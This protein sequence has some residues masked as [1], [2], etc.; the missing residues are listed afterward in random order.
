[1]CG[2]FPTKILPEAEEKLLTNPSLMELLPH[3]C[4]Y[5]I[6]YLYIAGRGQLKFYN[7]QKT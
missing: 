5:L 6:I 1:M 4:K 2:F 3:I 7:A